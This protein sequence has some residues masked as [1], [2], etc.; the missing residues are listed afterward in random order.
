[1]AKKITVHAGDGL[2]GWEVRTEFTATGPES[3]AITCFG[4]GRRTGRT[5]REVRRRLTWREVYGHAGRLATMMLE[6]DLRYAVEITGVG[7]HWQAELITAKMLRDTDWR[8]P[9]IL[10]MLASWPERDLLALRERYG[11]LLNTALLEAMT[12]IVDTDPAETPANL[13]GLRAAARAGEQ[14]WLEEI[15]DALE[16]PEPEAPGLTLEDRAA[17]LREF[18]AAEVKPAHPVL[19]GSQ[20]EAAYLQWLLESQATATAIFGQVLATDREALVGYL[21]EYLRVARPRVLRY[22][23]SPH[24]W[25]AM[26]FGRANSGCW[27]LV[28]EYLY[29]SAVAHG[30]C[31]PEELAVPEMPWLRPEFTALA[32]NS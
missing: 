12:R 19:D 2:M 8:L 29:R 15:A 32:V 4:N 20:N 22:T 13:A 23:Q 11:S 6:G 31:V 7:R 10:A 24:S 17:L 14:A 9:E 3:Y 21:H 5:L 16:D 18:L 30:V 28:A 1:M 25:V 27:A 26:T